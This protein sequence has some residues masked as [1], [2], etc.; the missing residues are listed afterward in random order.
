MNKTLKPETAYTPHQL[1]PEQYCK[2][3]QV[4][5]QQGQVDTLSEENNLDQ[6]TEIVGAAGGENLPLGPPKGRSS[7]L[8][9]FQRHGEDKLE[10]AERREKRL[11][12][13][14]G[15]SNEMQRGKHKLPN[16]SLRHPGDPNRR[17]CLR[18][19]ELF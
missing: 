19:P 17:G 5:N 2:L 9:Q 16:C 11:M 7:M 3:Q 4:I 14:L 10:T 18:R 12:E 13:L 15:Q 6:Y 1:T 8:P